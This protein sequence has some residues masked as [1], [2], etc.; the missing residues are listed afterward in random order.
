MLRDAVQL[1]SNQNDKR[2]MSHGVT[3]CPPLLDALPG[4]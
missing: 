2:G 4:L 1:T 3:R